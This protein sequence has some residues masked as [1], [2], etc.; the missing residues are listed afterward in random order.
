MFPIEP[1]HS[2][3]ASAYEYD[4]TKMFIT[5]VSLN[6]ITFTNGSVTFNPACY[7]P[8]RFGRQSLALETDNAN[9]EAKALE[10]ISISN[11]TGFCKKFRFFYSYFTDNT[12]VLTGHLDNSYPNIQTDKYRLKLDSLKEQSCDNS[13]INSPY[14]FTYYSNFLP[15]RLSFAQDHWGYYNG[16]VNER[17]VPSYS[18]GNNYFVAGANRDSKWPEMQNG[19]LTQIH[20]P[21][22]GFT[23]MEF[24][25]H[26]TWVN[27]TQYTP[28]PRNYYSVGY[29]G[30]SSAQFPNVAFTNNNYQVTI[31]N[32]A[33][34][35]GQ[36]S[37]S[38]I[39]TVY[40]VNSSSQTI[41][42]VTALGSETKTYVFQVPA[43]NYTVH[44]TRSN[45]Q[46]S[47]GAQVSF[48]EIVST[49]YQTN[50]MVGGLRIRK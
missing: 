10:S 32:A 25:P 37:A 39:A 24:E 17:L 47:A 7:R 46:T 38:C 27:T 14:K 49:P 41:P 3:P 50:A 29:D 18:I 11:T 6:Q 42:L 23:S 8:N 1:F 19:A 40:L 28:F 13:I 30:N 16:A 31:S 22:G 48:T 5:G 26:A 44:L 15:R 33:C 4:M 12:S 21:T 34:P 36:S 43:G 20:Y 45:S 35:S 9:T 2:N